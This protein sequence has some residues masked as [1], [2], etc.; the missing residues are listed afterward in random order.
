MVLEQY[1]SREFV[2][3]LCRSKCWHNKFK[4]LWITKPETKSFSN[5]PLDTVKNILGSIFEHE[6]RITVIACHR[7]T[8]ERCAGRLKLVLRL[9]SRIK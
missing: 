5:S 6:M 1:L 9:K 2:R 4:Y 8:G 7:V 3:E